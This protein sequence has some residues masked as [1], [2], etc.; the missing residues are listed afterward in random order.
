MKKNNIKVPLYNKVWR[1]KMN[2]ILS[3]F[4]TYIRNVH[5]FSMTFLPLYGK[6]QCKPNDNIF[7]VLSC[8]LTHK[9]DFVRL[10]FETHNAH[11]THYNF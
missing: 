5:F 10:L 6:N 4:V 2:V 3:N 11:Q 9:F 7:M 8:M 1:E